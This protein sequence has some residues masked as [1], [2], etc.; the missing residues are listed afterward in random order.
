[1]WPDKVTCILPLQQPFHWLNLSPAY[2]T[3]SRYF[4]LHPH[5]EDHTIMINASLDTTNINAINI[6]TLDIRILQHFNSNWTSPHLQKLA[7]VSEGP[8]T[9]LYKYMIDTGEPVHLFTIKDDDKNLSLIWTILMHPWTYIWG[10]GM[11]LAVCIGVYC[12]KRFW[13]RPAIPRCQP[14]SPAFS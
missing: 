9:Q 3:T 14:F 4:H 11:I 12:F 1:M 5:Y 2:S 7:I 8:V 10:F 6:S 13:I